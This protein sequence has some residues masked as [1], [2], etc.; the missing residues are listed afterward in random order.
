[1]FYLGKIRIKSFYH[2]ASR[3]CRINCLL[4][5]LLRNNLLILLESLEPKMLTSAIL[6][7][8][9]KKNLGSNN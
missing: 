5:K 1:M 3:L 6:R 2:L 7:K 8:I 9:E 4:R